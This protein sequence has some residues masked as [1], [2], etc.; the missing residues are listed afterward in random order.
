MIGF[1][2][3]SPLASP[4][5]THLAPVSFVFLCSELSLETSGS[6]P[7]SGEALPRWPPPAC[8]FPVLFFF[9]GHFCIL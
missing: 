4:D 5:T 3:P 9:H 8:V 2:P 7:V 1:R 6:F